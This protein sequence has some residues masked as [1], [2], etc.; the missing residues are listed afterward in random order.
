VILDDRAEA[1][2]EFR[3]S[4]IMRE[5][6][7]AGEWLR[8]RK[9]GCHPCA[10]RMNQHVVLLGRDPQLTVA[11]TPLSYLKCILISQNQL[12]E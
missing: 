9:T 6:P 3:K 10:I 7:L 8:V 1:A 5:P 12:K 2:Q 4:P 11:A